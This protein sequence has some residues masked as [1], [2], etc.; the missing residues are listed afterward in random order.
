MKRGGRSSASS[1]SSAT[2]SSSSSSGSGGGGGGGGGGII[3]QELLIQLLGKISLTLGEAVEVAA[4]RIPL[5]VPVLAVLLEYLGKEDPVA[6]TDKDIT[7]T[8]TGV[9]VSGSAKGQ[10]GAFSSSSSSID[11]DGKIT[12][13]VKS[14][15]Y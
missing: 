8:G 1:H 9:K 2:A 13:S 12:Y 14:G 7:D 10:K 4:I 11:G 3:T 15:K 5:L 6:S